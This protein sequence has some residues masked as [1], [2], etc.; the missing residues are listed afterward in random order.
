[1]HNTAPHTDRLEN[2]DKSKKLELW[3][4]NLLFE[5]EQSVYN[6][7]MFSLLSWRLFVGLG[8]RQTVVSD[9]QK[10]FFLISKINFILYHNDAMHGLHLWPMPKKISKFVAFTDVLLYNYNSLLRSQQ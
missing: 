9:V 8:L 6:S 10:A 7:K 4:L 3:L 1:M 5:N 2:E